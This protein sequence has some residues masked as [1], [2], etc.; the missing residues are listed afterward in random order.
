MLYFIGT[1]SYLLRRQQYL[2]QLDA[3]DLKI[4]PSVL[5]YQ[6]KISEPHKLNV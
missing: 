2:S 5:S 3:D 1:K 4:D 6:V